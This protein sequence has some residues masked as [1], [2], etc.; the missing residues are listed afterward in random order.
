MRRTSF[1]A[2]LLLIAIGAL[3]MARNLYPDLP[4]LDFTARYWPAVLIA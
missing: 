1:V 4:L 2:P 3:F